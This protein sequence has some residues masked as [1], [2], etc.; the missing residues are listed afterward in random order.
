[1]DDLI[2]ITPMGRLT[3]DDLWRE[4]ETLGFV[5]VWTT[6]NFGDTAKTGYDVKIFGRIKNSK[7][8]VERKHTSLECAFSDAINEAREMGLGEQQ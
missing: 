8:E 2:P 5:R 6:T 7:I 3:L 4:A 1:M